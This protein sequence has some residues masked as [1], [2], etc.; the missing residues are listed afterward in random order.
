MNVG[1]PQQLLSNRA[2]TRLAQLQRE[3]SEELRTLATQQSLFYG[4]MQ[5]CDFATQRSVL[6]EY[7]DRLDTVIAAAGRLRI[8]I[9]RHTAATL[10][11]CESNEP[12]SD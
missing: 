5:A 11:D 3:L 9:S 1:N 2:Q 10:V 7:I 8:F 4:A 12:I 6:G